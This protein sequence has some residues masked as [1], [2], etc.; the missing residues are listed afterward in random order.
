MPDTKLE[1]AVSYTLNQ[2]EYLTLRQGRQH[3]DRQQPSGTR[4]QDFACG[5]KNWLF[6][7]TV[8]G[9][10]A[11]AVIY[12]LMLTCRACRIEPF[13]WLKHV[14]AQLP[15]RPDEADVQDQKWTPDFGLAA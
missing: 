13:A 9:A 8:E 4:Y 1:D 15:T 3:A 12:S 11:S 10:R 7:A 6:S 2:W 14:L 5:R